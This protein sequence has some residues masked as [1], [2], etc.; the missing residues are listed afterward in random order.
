MNPRR[1]LL[2]VASF[3]LIL[4]E[5]NAKQGIRTPIICTLE[6]EKIEH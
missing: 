5:L 4:E 2:V 6:E 1:V 3:A